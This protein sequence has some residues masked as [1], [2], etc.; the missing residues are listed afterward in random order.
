MLTGKGDT[1]DKVGGINAGADDYIVKPFEPDELLA[2]IRMIIRR[3]SRDLDANPLT[4]LPGNLSI[5]N[6]IQNKIDT[7]N[8]LFEEV[9]QRIF[10]KWSPE[11]ISGYLK[12][13]Y[14]GNLQMQISHESIYK[15]IYAK[16]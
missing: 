16:S 5:L 2:R 14:V 10:K 7:N 6:E 12:D 9:F 4:R 11:Q 13:K 1:A 15:Y 8:D 3:A